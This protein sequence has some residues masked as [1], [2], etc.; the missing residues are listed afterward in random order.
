[1][2]I[3]YGPT[4]RSLSVVNLILLACLFSPLGVV[5]EQAVPVESRLHNIVVAVVVWLYLT[6]MIVAV[7]F[8][9]LLSLPRKRTALWPRHRRRLD[10]MLGV[11]WLVVFSAFVVASFA[12]LI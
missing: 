9:C 1:M 11:A 10:A 3:Q 4:I 2:T 5:W 12:R 8:A 6:S 7:L